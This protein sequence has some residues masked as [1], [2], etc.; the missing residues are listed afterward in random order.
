MRERERMHGNWFVSTFL[1]AIS[2]LVL[3]IGP[4][5]A[6]LLY[7]YSLDVGLTCFG[8]ALRLSGSL[9]YWVLHMLERGGSV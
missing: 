7:M 5:L 2:D 6:Y 3:L 4:L 9:R 8:L 1:Y